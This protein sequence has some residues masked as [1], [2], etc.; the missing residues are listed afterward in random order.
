MD[1]GIGRDS[2]KYAQLLIAKIL[3]CLAA[4]ILMLAYMGWQRIKTSAFSK[5][6]GQE[7]RLVNDTNDASLNSFE[8]KIITSV[9]A[10]PSSLCQIVT[11]PIHFKDFK[12]RFPEN[13]FSMKVDKKK[14]KDAEAI[15]KQIMNKQII[16]WDEIAPKPFADEE[17]ALTFDNIK[18]S[19]FYEH[20]EERF[21]ICEN[22][23]EYQK[24]YVLE[25]DEKRASNGIG[26]QLTVTVYTV[27]ATNLMTAD[28][29]RG[30]RG[31]D[32][33]IQE[34]M[35]LRNVVHFNC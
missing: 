8:S 23:T 12:L 26:N 15:G 16:D 2:D 24:F 34:T 27:V 17:S 28:F 22:T 14:N 4:L 20:S 31:L 32:V 5:K 7:K 1:F 25:H 6:I 10:S 21:Y 13:H 3:L 29:G 30:D 9:K 18:Y 33:D 11:N 19:M 35:A